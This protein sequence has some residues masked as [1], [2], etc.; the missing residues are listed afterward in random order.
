MSAPLVAIIPHRLGKAEALR[1]LREGLGR[2]Q[3]QANLFLNVE[4]ATWEGDRV[5]FRVR[6]LGQTAAAAIDVFEQEVRLE[7]TLPW[8]LQKLADRI[9]P[10]L[11][12]E[13]T[14]LL[15]KK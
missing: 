4:P 1:R 10:A 5:T 3:T 2:A 13:T 9:L 6:A 11:R 7:V 14:L 8:L 15:N 12:R